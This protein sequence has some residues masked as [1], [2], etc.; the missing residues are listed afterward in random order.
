MSAS[1]RD[2]RRPLRAGL[3]GAPGTG[4]LHLADDLD[5]AL[6]HCEDALLRERQLYPETESF[7]LHRHLR[8]MF[9][10]ERDVQELMRYVERIEVAPNDYVIRQGDRSDD[11]YFIERG[12][13][14]I[15]LELEDGATLR[16]KTMGPGTVVGE[17]AMYLERSRSASVVAETETRTCRLRKETLR[18]LRE[19]NPRAAAMFHEF[20]ARTLA[21]KLVDT[22]RLVE[23]ANR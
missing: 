9:A 13:V 19:Q 3:S 1:P 20:L 4:R 6:E 16:L 7:E 10:D 18:A 23:A 8:G 15:Q 17:L 2:I 5:H 12:Q 22:N 21:E 11:L 14:T